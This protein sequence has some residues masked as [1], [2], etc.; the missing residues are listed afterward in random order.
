[1]RK[2]IHFE[3]IDTMQDEQSILYNFRKPGDRVITNP[4]INR[5]YQSKKA[6]GEDFLDYARLEGK[7]YI[8]NASC[9]KAESSFMVHGYTFWQFLKTAPESVEWNGIF[10][11]EYDIAM[12]D[13]SINRIVE[14]HLSNSMNADEECLWA[15]GTPFCKATGLDHDEILEKVLAFLF[16]YE[17]G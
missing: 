1:M 5:D 4:K 7:T 14:P 3:V 11:S 10:A 13:G 6:R 15:G 2:H 12:S 17:N 16:A 9:G 8:L